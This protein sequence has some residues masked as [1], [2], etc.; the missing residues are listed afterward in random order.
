MIKICH[1][2]EFCYPAAANWVRLGPGFA[3]AK[4]ARNTRLTRI[5]ILNNQLQ[6]SISS[7]IPQGGGRVMS[8]VGFV[9]LPRTTTDL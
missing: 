9:L 8:L 4:G 3:S 5:I 6:R 1:G 2:P 7:H